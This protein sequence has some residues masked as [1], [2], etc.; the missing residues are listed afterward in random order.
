MQRKFHPLS[1]SVSSYF[2]FPNVCDF[3]LTEENNFSI[4]A[5]VMRGGRVVTG[6]CSV[7]E[8]VKV[9]TEISS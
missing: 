3:G 2:L 1:A 7:L 4:G 6:R 8:L 5:G 9:D